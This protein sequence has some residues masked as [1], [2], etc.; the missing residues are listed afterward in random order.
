MPESTKANHGISF[1]YFVEVE[2]S[3]SITF[4][5]D[6]GSKEIRTETYQ[7]WLTNLIQSTAASEWWCN[8]RPLRIGSK[9]LFAFPRVPDT[10][11][12]LQTKYFFANLPFTKGSPLA[13]PLKS[14]ACLFS[15][16]T[17]AFSLLFSHS[18]STSDEI[19]R[20]SIS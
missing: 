12:S 13:L 15:F 11:S 10:L 6:V 3:K 19:Q 9:W 1:C 4:E 7:P 16:C 2:Q 8:F 14:V 18:Y 20:S 17:S 5:I